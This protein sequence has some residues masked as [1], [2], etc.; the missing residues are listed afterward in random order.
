MV[1]SEPP[2]IIITR[3]HTGSTMKDTSRHLVAVIANPTSISRPEKMSSIGA[4]GMLCR[5]L[6]SPSMWNIPRCLPRFSSKARDSSPSSTCA[7]IDVL[8]VLLKKLVRVSCRELCN[9]QSHDDREKR[10]DADV[11]QQPPSSLTSEDESVQQHKGDYDGEQTICRVEPHAQPKTCP[12]AMQSQRRVL[13]QLR[14]YVNQA[15]RGGKERRGYAMH[16]DAAPGDVPAHHRR[17]KGGDK[18]YRRTRHVPHHQEHCQHTGDAEGYRYKPSCRN[19]DASKLD[20]Q[21]NRQ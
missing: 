15:A 5:P 13:Y 11:R 12:R 17:Q 3:T 9:R 8:C 18:P 14:R 6:G 4:R 21:R 7:K 19:R 1:S 2:G 20:N 10:H 16:P